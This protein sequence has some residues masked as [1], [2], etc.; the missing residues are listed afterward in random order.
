M[1]TPSEAKVIESI[2]VFESKGLD[3]PPLGADTRLDG[4]LRLESLDFAELVIRL[5]ARFGFDDGQ[6]SPAARI[7]GLL[8]VEVERER[9]V[10]GG[11]AGTFA[12]VEHDAGAAPRCRISVDLRGAWGAPAS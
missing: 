5:E 8:T 9:C 10:R 12:G 11:G 2:A 7:R 4:S 1:P 6:L 3:P